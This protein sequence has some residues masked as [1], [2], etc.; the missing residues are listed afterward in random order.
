MTNHIW[1][2][3]HI[4]FNT[5]AWKRLPDDLQAIAYKNFSAAAMTE[6]DDWQPAPTSELRER[7]HATKTSACAATNAGKRPPVNRAAIDSPGTTE[8]IVISTRLGGMVSD[9]AL[10]VASSD[11]SSPGC[12]AGSVDGAYLRDRGARPDLAVRHPLLRH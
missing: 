8:P 1:I 7:H 9:I 10:D 12:S 4:S 11:E 2:G 6:R 5:T 3:L